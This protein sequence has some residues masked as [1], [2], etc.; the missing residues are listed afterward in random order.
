MMRAHIIGIVVIAAAVATAAAASNSTDGREGGGR[1]KIIPTA[2]IT[3]KL[4]KNPF[5]HVPTSGRLQ[6]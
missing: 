3:E 6:A 5:V 4:L 2:K 1:R